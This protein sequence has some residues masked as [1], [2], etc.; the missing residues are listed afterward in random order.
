M[1]KIYR[2]LTKDQKE[3]N[4][5]FSSCLS[6][7]KEENG[8]IHEV[9]L[10]DTNKEEKILRLLKDNFFDNSFFNYNIIRQ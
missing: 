1:K 7:T 8:T 5:I 10:R 9:G 2:N 3:R 4:I 6:E